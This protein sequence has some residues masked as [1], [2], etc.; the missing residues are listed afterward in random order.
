MLIFEKVLEM[1]QGYLEMDMSWRYAGAGT[2]MFAY[3]S[4][5]H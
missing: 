5:E 4:A 3:P 2:D 1:F